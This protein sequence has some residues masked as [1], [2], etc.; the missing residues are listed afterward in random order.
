MASLT[1]HYEED[2]PQ[3]Q[4]RHATHN[5]ST[6]STTLDGHLANQQNSNIPTTNAMSVAP[7]SHCIPHRASILIP[8]SIKTTFLAELRS[9][10]T[11]IFE[12]KLFMSVW[13]L[14]EA[15]LFVCHFYV[16]MHKV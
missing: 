5:R 1:T 2:M 15:G 13:W 11:N 8:P 7:I 4:W 12:R 16:C 10:S 6:P 14:Q 9:E 3:G